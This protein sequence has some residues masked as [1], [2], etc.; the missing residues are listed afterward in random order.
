MHLIVSFPCFY[1]F[2]C[3]W[4]EAHATSWT[5]SAA[6][7]LILQSHAVDASAIYHQMMELPVSLRH[8]THSL[9]H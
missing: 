5:P 8:R 3:L 2:G 1:N 9:T 6:C 7:Y 4:G